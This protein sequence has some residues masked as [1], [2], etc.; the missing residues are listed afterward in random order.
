MGLPVHVKHTAPCKTEPDWT[1]ST[2]QERRHCSVRSEAWGRA[3]SFSSLSL[4][5][6]IASPAMLSRTWT[7]PH[8]PIS[9]EHWKGFSFWRTLCCLLTWKDGLLDTT[10]YLWA[11]K[12]MSLYHSLLFNSLSFLGTEVLASFAIC[13]DIMGPRVRV[14][15]V[16]F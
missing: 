4:S 3:I 16:K 10:K 1:H 12:Q 8:D 5:H 7:L 11:W 6:K 13:S 9:G 15:Q 14:A 2:Q